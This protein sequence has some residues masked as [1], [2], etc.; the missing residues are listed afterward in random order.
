MK[1]FIVPPVIVPPPETSY[2][3]SYT[4]RSGECDPDGFLRFSALCDYL[5]ETAADHAFKTGF[6]KGCDGIPENI[7]WVLTRLRVELERYPAWRDEVVTLTFPRGMRK[8]FA[9]RDFELSL[10]NG[11]V[12]GRAAS[13]WMVVDMATRRAQRVPEKIAAYGNTVRAPALGEAP[14]GKFEFG[15]GI[16]EG[17]R[18]VSTRKEFTAQRS[19]ID[20]NGHV[21]NVRYFEWMLETAPDAMKRPLSFEAVF[22]AEVLE[23]ETVVSECVC[24]NGAAYLKIS[25][26]GKESVIARIK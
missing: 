24:G 4:A 25:A 13:E 7:T 23:G 21:N 9:Y 12:I 26:N 19:H 5:Q 15:D 18:T 16:G 3:T 10:A 1:T 11:E 8:L 20:V 22:R 17:G 6:G 14:F 2:E